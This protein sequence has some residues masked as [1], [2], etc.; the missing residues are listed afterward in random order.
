MDDRTF[1]YLNISLI[2]F[3]LSGPRNP[4][5]R[6]LFSYFLFLRLSLGRVEVLSQ[7]HFYF[8]KFV[9]DIFRSLLLFLDPIEE[10]NF[11]Y[12]IEKSLFNSAR[13]LFTRCK[14][15]NKKKIL[16]CMMVTQGL[17]FF[18]TKTY[19]KSQQDPKS[20]VNTNRKPKAS[21]GGRFKWKSNL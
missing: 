20:F 21:Y 5:V 11:S 8:V 13:N 7:T 4:K 17:M 18:R 14:I 10:A 15:P 9:F 3:F 6:K 19:H 2:V 16:F 1:I 12:S